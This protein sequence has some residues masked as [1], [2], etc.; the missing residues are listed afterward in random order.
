[1]PS[2]RPATEATIWYADDLGA[3][4]LRARFGD[5]AYDLH[6]HDTACFALITSGAI[7]IR[8][9]GGEFV[10][11]AGDLYAID[12]DEPHAGWPVDDAGWSQRTIYVDLDGLHR[13]L[14]QKDGPAASLRGPIIRDAQL[15]QTFLAVHASY[16]QSASTLHRDEH[17]LAFSRRLFERHISQTGVES[18]VGRETRAVERA[19]DFLDARLDRRVS[20][21][22]IAT[23]SGLPPFR[24]YRAFERET[25]MTPHGYQRQ[26]R[27]RAALDLIRRGLP[28]VEVANVAGFADQAHF[29]RSFR[30]RM[31][32]TPG[33]YR[34]ARLGVA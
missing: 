2:K 30:A 31:G 8:M 19:R 9:K 26:A 11:H 23:A 5:F 20:L 3:E 17:Y 34:E 10:A 13:R 28:L 24:I 18:D 21:A 29:T 12:A 15:A 27:I 25:G 33:A 4:L 6:T 16:E 1:M 7:G 22:E 14:F 32:V